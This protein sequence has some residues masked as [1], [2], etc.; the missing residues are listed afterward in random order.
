[1]RKFIFAILL[2]F[3]TSSNGEQGYSIVDE[4]NSNTAQPLIFDV[5]S[6]IECDVEPDLLITSNKTNN[7]INQITYLFNDST[8]KNII[9]LNEKFQYLR[10]RAPPLNIV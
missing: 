1:M 6:D 7:R 8:N 10:P 4:K 2:F 9:L 3:I 5:S